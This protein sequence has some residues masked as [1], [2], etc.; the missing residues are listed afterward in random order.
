VER[1]EQALREEKA[2]LAQGKREASALRRQVK[3]AERRAR[4]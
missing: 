2:R 3:A 4:G 1:A